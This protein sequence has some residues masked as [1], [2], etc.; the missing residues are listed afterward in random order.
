MAFATHAP[1]VNWRK[2]DDWKWVRKAGLEEV[3]SDIISHVDEGL[4]RAFIRSLPPLDDTNIGP[5]TGMIDNKQIAWNLKY[6][7][8]I[9]NLSKGCKYRYNEHNLSH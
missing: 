3:Y 5:C 8:I 9:F 7:S 4:C 6:L 1:S 2:I